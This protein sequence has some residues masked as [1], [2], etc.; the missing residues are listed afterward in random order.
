MR[1][2]SV[3]NFTQMD[4]AIITRII[5]KHTIITECVRH[6]KLLHSYI[7]ITN[8]CMCTVQCTFVQCICSLCIFRIK[9]H[10]DRNFYYYYFQTSR[11]IQIISHTTNISIGWRHNLSDIRTLFHIAISSGNIHFITRLICIHKIWGCLFRH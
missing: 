2:I 5:I 10:K 1:F 3:L 9:W 4:G 6:N 11:L 7:I 8:I